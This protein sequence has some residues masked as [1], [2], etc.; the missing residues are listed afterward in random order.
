[1]HIYET[2]ISPSLSLYTGCGHPW[3]RVCLCVVAKAQGDAGASRCRFLWPYQRSRLGPAA[4]MAVTRLGDSLGKGE[5][6]R[7]CEGWPQPPALHRTEEAEE[8][9]W[10]GAAGAGKDRWVG[11]WCFSF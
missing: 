10:R 11:G 6:E 9:G 7:G 4:K 3:V 5:A 1:M 8:W 2:K